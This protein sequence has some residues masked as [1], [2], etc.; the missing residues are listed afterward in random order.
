MS[1]KK[2]KIGD[3]AEIRTPRGLA[4]VQYTHDG[5]GNGEIVR[6]LPGLYS[7]RPNLETLICQRELY[8]I[9]YT[10]KYA[11]REKQSE[12]VCNLPV[13]EWARP[14]PLM[15][16]ASGR[17][18]EGN[19]TGWRIVPALA[20][21]TIDFLRRTPVIRELAQEQKRLSIHLIRPHPVMVKELARGWTPERAEDFENQDRLE[22]IARKGDPRLEP[23]PSEAMSHY[24]YFKTL[25]DAESVREELRERGY[26][27]EVRKGADGDNWLALAKGERPKTREEMDKLRNEM[28]SLAAQHSGDYDGWEIAAEPSERV[29]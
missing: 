26:R 11:I 25:T 2:L 1:A 20:T 7:S 16:H 3:V 29:N 14:E 5:K 21:L 10:L 18:A 17:S 4:Y 9:F 12:I 6:V 28:E 24:L 27:V 8:F 23:P 15:R 22:S 19:V 13:P